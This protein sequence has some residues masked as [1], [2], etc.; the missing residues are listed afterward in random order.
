[1]TDATAAHD[2]QMGTYERRLDMLEKRTRDIVTA[3][4]ARAANR[5]IG[6]S[7]SRHAANRDLCFYPAI[8]AAIATKCPW[9]RFYCPA[10]RK[11]ATLICACSTAIVAR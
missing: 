1:L 8:G 10:Y 3:K 9:L 4:A 7:N 5:V 2:P 6:I 11:L